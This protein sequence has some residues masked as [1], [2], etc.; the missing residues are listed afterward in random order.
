MNAKKILFEKPPVIS[1]TDAISVVKK[2]YDQHEVQALPLV[3]EG[4]I[5]LIYRHQ[6]SNCDPDKRLN[7]CQLQPDPTHVYEQ[8]HLL[9][10]ISF[11][12]SSHKDSIAVL[13]DEDNFIGI[14]SSREII[15]RLGTMT[16]FQGQ[17]SVMVLKVHEHDYSLSQMAQIVESHNAKILFLYVDQ[18]KDTSMLQVNLRITTTELQSMIQQ[19]ERFQFNVEATYIPDSSV[20]KNLSDRY[21]SLMRFLDV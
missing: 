20:Q 18:V 14:I 5:G 21:D 9:E 4:F 8:Q 12:A 10:I 3:E 19:F 16:A 15:N 11:M 13:D 2:L 17:G 6:L 1:L 7:E